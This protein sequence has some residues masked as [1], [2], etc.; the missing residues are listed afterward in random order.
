MPLILYIALKEYNTIYKWLIKTLILLKRTRWCCVKNLYNN[1]QSYG[2]IS[3]WLH[4]GMAIF[5][6]ALISIG[7]YM[8]GLDDTDPNRFKMMGMHKSFG[9]IFMMLAILRL[10]WVRISRSPSLPKA[11]SGW[12][13][14]LS[15]TIT[16]F[17][18]TLMLAIPF[19][20][21]AMTNFAG[22][23]VSLFGALELP[24]IFS[25]DIEM[26]KLAK[27]AHGTLVYALLLSVFFHVAGA[28]KHRFLDSPDVDVLP[29]MTGIKKRS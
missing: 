7:T 8:T 11:L 19:S 1:E 4:W 14:L 10:I 27:D 12:E 22:Y 21:Y 17:L 24:Q 13:V 9:A 16:F 25:K 3:K 29:R 15:R 2:Q 26:A 28:L 23:P 20:G 5:L 6:I 18:Y